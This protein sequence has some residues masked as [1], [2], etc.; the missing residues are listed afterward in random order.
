MKVGDKVKVVQSGLIYNSYDSMIDVVGLTGRARRDV[1]TGDTGTVV[2]IHEH[3]QTPGKMLAIVDVQIPGEYL[4][5]GIH[6]VEVVEEVDLIDSLMSELRPSKREQVQS[7]LDRIKVHNGSESMA[8]GNLIV[9][10]AT[11][12]QVRS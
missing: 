8:M 12:R 1:E 3:T 9:A 4:V 5:I 10:L 11:L 7:R 6:G 2:A